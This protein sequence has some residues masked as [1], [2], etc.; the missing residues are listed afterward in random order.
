MS[1]KSSGAV[2]RTR[3]EV[4]QPQLVYPST[5]NENIFENYPLFLNSERRKIRKKLTETPAKQLA[6]FQSKIQKVE[7]HLQSLQQASPRP[8]R[9]G[10][11]SN[12]AEERL[13]Q[14][15][16]FYT[17]H[18]ED[19]HRRLFPPIQRS[20]RVLPRSGNALSNLNLNENPNEN[21]TT[22]TE[23]VYDTV[24]E[25]HS[26]DTTLPTPD[27]KPSSK[28]PESSISGTLVTPTNNPIRG[29][30]SSS[31]T[32]TLTNGTLPRTEQHPTY[33]TPRES[34]DLQQKTSEALL[35][36]ESPA[37]Q[38]PIPPTLPESHLPR[39]ISPIR[40]TPSTT[41]SP[42]GLTPQG[43]RAISP[44]SKTNSSRPSKLFTSSPRPYI[45]N[46]ERLYRSP[47]RQHHGLF[48][49]NQ[50]QDQSPKSEQPTRPANRSPSQSP[51]RATPLNSTQNNDWDDNF[52]NVDNSPNLQLG[53]F[54]LNLSSIHQQ[55]LPTTQYI[56]QNLSL[57]PPPENLLN[58]PLEPVTNEDYPDSDSLPELISLSD[59][60]DI[61]ELIPPPN[62][63]TLVARHPG[64]NDLLFEENLNLAEM[65]EIMRRLAQSHEQA[66]QSLVDN[67]RDMGANSAKQQIPLFSGKLGDQ[68]VHEW[69]EKADRIAIAEGWDEPRKLRYYQQ[70]LIKPA[71]A[72][73]DTIPEE[74]RTTNFPAWRTA[75]ITGFADETTKNRWKHDLENLKQDPNERVRDFVSRI[76]NLY[77]QVHGPGPANNQQ[78][79]V[80]A[81]REDTKKKIFLNGVRRDVY[82]NIWSRVDPATTWDNVI[83]TAEQVEA[84]IEK[85]QILEQRPEIDNA[86]AT[87][88]K[89]NAKL[90]QDIA[91]I[92]DQ[93][94]KLT[95]LSSKQVTENTIAAV[96]AQQRTESRPRV[97][98]AN[99]ASYRERSQSRESLKSPTRYHNQRERP[100]STYSTPATRSRDNYQ[101]RPQERHP[102]NTRNYPSENQQN[103]QQRNPP[104][105]YYNRNPGKEN[106]DPRNNGPPADP[107]RTIVC[108]YCN[109]PGH[110][111]RECRTRMYHMANQMADRNH[112]HQQKQQTN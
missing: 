104:R 23:A 34:T 27:L 91:K 2:P 68:T 16:I 9:S 76:N 82:S 77:L 38:N 58:I 105:Q 103:Y 94:E 69:L 48:V 25:S 47:E 41:N 53:N 24:P 71:S 19:I 74:T 37:V 26:D 30:P 12:R 5:T 95:V 102:S 61:P 36:P 78:A 62:S 86:V 106:R 51:V 63:P 111:Q 112:G 3:V 54:F 10:N 70:R 79:D 46:T 85:K 29:Q 60:E 52:T 96:S 8:T 66:T 15:F 42:Q 98:F 40:T 84:I 35:A 44:S 45:R 55:S 109:K 4:E 67:L 50:D 11:T 75:F 18:Y 100:S 80:T 39:A 65:E 6:W 99:D 73:N 101:A 17:K 108:Y 92:S 43:A 22:T 83:T 21:T 88:I 64:V 56:N 7:R 107:P 87:V 57:P 90:T 20:P 33:L 14:H 89:E 1:T 72:F 81:L 97:R 49:T 13:M 31:P 59:D 93:I 32:A 110:I 28:R